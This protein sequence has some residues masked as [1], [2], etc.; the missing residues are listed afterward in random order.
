MTRA[1]IA[2]VR[3]FMMPSLLLALDPPG[4]GGASRI[5]ASPS[6]LGRPLRKAL[7]RPHWLTATAARA[8]VQAG[9]CLADAREPRF[10][11]RRCGVASRWT[12]R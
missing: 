1:R 7:A 5:R 12:A 3:V 11:R 2:I 8:V 6:S 10:S 9:H 4:R